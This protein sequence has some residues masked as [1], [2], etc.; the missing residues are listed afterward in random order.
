M[1]LAHALRRLTPKTSGSDGE[2]GDGRGCQTPDSILSTGSR[3]GFSSLNAMHHPGKLKV[4][5]LTVFTV[6]QPYIIDNLLSLDISMS[7]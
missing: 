3:S 5:Y 2:V 7:K 1:D 6:F 4:Y